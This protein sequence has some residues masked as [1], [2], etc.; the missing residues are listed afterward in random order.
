ML[1]TPDWTAALTARAAVVTAVGTSLLAAGV[2]V[3]AL[4]FRDQRRTSRI[5]QTPDLIKSW[6]SPQLAA[7][8]ALLDKNADM[9]RNRRRANT[10]FARTSNSPN[11][12]LFGKVR[13]ALLAFIHLTARSAENIEV[14]VRRGAADEGIIAEHIGYGIVMMYLT[15]QDVLATLALT[16][17]RDYEG[18]RLLGLR[19]QAY[20][21]LHQG[22]TNMLDV[23]TWTELPALLYSKRRPA[24]APRVDWWNGFRLRFVKR[25]KSVG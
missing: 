18:W 22:D 4:Q 9:E 15:L 24:A 17:N 5:V 12:S 3:A 7:M 1:E 19:C 6:A 11:A 21:K 13:Q 10:V 8:R 14:Y 2:V 20:S 16:E 25:P 23:L